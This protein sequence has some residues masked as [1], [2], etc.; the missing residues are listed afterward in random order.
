MRGLDSGRWS[1]FFRSFAKTHDIAWDKLPAGT[2]QKTNNLNDPLAK[3][4]LAFW[5]I[6]NEKPNPYGGSSWSS[7]YTLYPGVLAV[8][9]NGKIQYM[10]RGGVTSKGGRDTSPSQ[11][12]GQAGYGML[13]VNKLKK[14]ADHLLVMDFESFR[15]GTTALKAKRADLKLGKDTF[16]D[17]RKWKQANLSR[18]KQILDA[19]V[20]SRDQV[21]TMVGKIVKIANEAVAT[22]METVKMGKYDR[23]M[24][25]ING[26]EVEME[27][28]TNAMGRALSQYA[29]YIRYMN[30]AEKSKKAYG[31]GEYEDKAA[32]DIAGKLK[33]IMLGFQ[34]GDQRE[35]SR[36]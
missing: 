18:Y 6:D 21:D 13:M 14:M 28:V 5:M 25:T 29:E 7:S 2:V 16:T 31:G 12:V 4:G 15:G 19:R 10:S 1:N 24:T 35:F 20:G 22:G 36:Y 8:T 23:M 3:K 34:K 27:A 33:K 30:R 26:N 9:L 11:A 17:H 32:K